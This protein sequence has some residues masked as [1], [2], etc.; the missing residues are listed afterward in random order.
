MT[1]AC[2]RVVAAVTGPTYVLKVESIGISD[3]VNIRC[4]DEEGILM[5]EST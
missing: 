5:E 3:R 2:S 1:L 4:D